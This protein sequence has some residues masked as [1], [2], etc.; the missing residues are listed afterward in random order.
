MSPTHYKNDNIDPIQAIT[1]RHVR[2]WFESTPQYSVALP[3]DSVFFSCRT[4]LPVA[5]ENV[6]WVHNATKH[7]ARCH[8]PFFY[9]TRRCCD[10][11]FFAILGEKGVFHRN[12]CYYK[13]FA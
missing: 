1:S 5:E 3:G 4:N 6:T 9:G 11:S 12:Q 13:I 2:L 10:H 8:A 7:L